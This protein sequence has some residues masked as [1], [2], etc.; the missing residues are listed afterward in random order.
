MVAA[1]FVYPNPANPS[2]YVVVHTGVTPA[3]VYY[4]SHLPWLL[5][6]YVIYDGSKWN[7]RNGMLFGSDRQVI[8]GGFFD[9][10]WKL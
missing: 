8:D 3:A 2:R 6:D 4:A 9:S 7:R 1:S 10:C 5:P